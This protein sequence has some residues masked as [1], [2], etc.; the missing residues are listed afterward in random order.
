MFLVCCNRLNQGALY[1]MGCDEIIASRTTITLR[2][3][4]LMQEFRQYPC[5]I[6]SGVLVKGLH[7][8]QSRIKVTGKVPVCFKYRDK[9]ILYGS[10]VCRDQWQGLFLHLFR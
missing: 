10:Q 6:F 8:Y 4:S 9:T 3:Q 2:V 7:V 1:C 5:N